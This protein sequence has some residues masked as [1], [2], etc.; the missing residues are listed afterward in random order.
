MKIREER[1]QIIRLSA[2]FLVVLVASL[3]AAFLSLRG[4]GAH[5]PQGSPAPK[6]L[7]TLEGTTVATIEE[8]GLRATAPSGWHFERSDRPDTLKLLPDN[9]SSECAMTI[10]HGSNEGTSATGFLNLYDLGKRFGATI[11]DQEQKII[12]VSS[13]KGAYFAFTD[14]SSVRRRELYLSYRTSLLTVRYEERATSEAIARQAKPCLWDFD[15]FIGHGIAVP[16]P[17]E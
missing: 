12:D 9:P 14:A 7:F 17:Q 1:E 5:A 15:W 4:R 2:I 8:T 10:T 3:A 6:P 13:W 16:A 11:R